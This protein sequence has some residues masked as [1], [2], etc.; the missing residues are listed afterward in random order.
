MIEIVMPK[1]PNATPPKKTEKKNFFVILVPSLCIKI[2]AKAGKCVVPIIC[3]V[4]LIISLL[5]LFSK[6][7]CASSAYL[8]ND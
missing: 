3:A 7:F 5:N 4:K 1:G 6:S 8:S 2:C